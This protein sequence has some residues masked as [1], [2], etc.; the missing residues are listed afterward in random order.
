MK[1]T[2]FGFLIIVSVVI[3][4]TGCAVIQ[5]IEKNDA[6]LIGARIAAKRIGYAIAQNNPAQSAEMVAYAELLNNTS[7]NDQLLNRALPMALD[8]LD[9][10]ARACDPVL[11]SDIA[12]LLSLIQLQAPDVDIATKSALAKAAITGF[13]E[14]CKLAAK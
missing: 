11:L 9:G 12:D 3:A 1:K 13:I 2:W 4:L 7:D 5:N 8:K 10:Y 14:G 6:T